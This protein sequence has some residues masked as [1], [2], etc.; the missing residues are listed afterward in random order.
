MKISFLHRISIASDDG[1]G[2]SEMANKDKIYHL[3]F[4]VIS[5]LTVFETACNQLQLFS[6]WQ[7]LLFDLADHLDYTD[8]ASTLPL[9]IVIIANDSESGS[10]YHWIL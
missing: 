6:T 7:L 10:V 1:I 2:L 3:M 8:Y 9:R 5:I 4:P